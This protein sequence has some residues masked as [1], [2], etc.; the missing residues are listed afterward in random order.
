M[1]LR[2]DRSNFM[3]PSQNVGPI[4]MKYLERGKVQQ[5]NKQKQLQLHGLFPKYQH[6]YV[7][8]TLERGLT[9]RA[10]VICNY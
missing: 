6:N 3:G 1:Y 8:E 9:Y 2:M 10:M 5:E 4:R 7:S